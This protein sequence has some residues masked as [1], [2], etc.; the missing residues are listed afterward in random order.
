MQINSFTKPTL[1][2]DLGSTC[3]FAV[4][5]KYGVTS[6]TLSFKK[7]GKFQDTGYAQLH[8][9]L[10]VTL[11]SNPELEVV[12]EKPHSGRFMAASRI[13]FGL[14]GVVHMFCA[15]TKTTLT[16]YSPKAIKK[17]WTGNG[18]SDKDAM[19]TQ[20]QTKYPQVKDHNESD[21]LAMLHMHLERIK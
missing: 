2:L 17:Y 7:K 20:T 19:V 4:H 3:G 13:L 10:K 21:A 18:N 6:G 5:N 15:D 1:A 14:L 9:W 12:V 11:D 8:T 16:E